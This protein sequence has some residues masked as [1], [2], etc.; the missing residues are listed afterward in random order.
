MKTIELKTSNVKF[1]EENHVYTLNGKRL[2]GITR[3][4]DAVYHTYSGVD[5]ETLNNAAQVG[6]AYHRQ[7]QF[8]I[9]NGF[10]SEECASQKEAERSM[11]LSPIKCEYLV[12][13]NERIASAIDVVYINADGEITLGDIKTTAVE[14]HD[15]W[16]LQL[17]IYKYLFELQT[18]LEVKSLIVA[19]VDKKTHECR[20]RE[21]MPIER[22]EVKRIVDEYFEGKLEIEKPRQQGVEVIR[23]YEDKLLGYLKM[24]KEI[25]EFKDKFNEV[26]LEYMRA[27]GDKSYKTDNISITRVMETTKKTF[28]SKKF[29]EDC[30]ELFKKYQKESV[31]KEHL[32]IK[33]I[34]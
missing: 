33:S 32:L 6:K 16:R 24:E 3:I 28:D 30:P 29:K 31:T 19:H 20:I 8:D 17:S 15:E 14:H 18:E 7:Y 23:Q 12:S 10:E 2:Q 1:D 26:V 5:E 21:V 34:A 27:N 9:E 22:D 13:D 11:G 4:I 25:K